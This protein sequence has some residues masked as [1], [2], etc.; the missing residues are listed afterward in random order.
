[1]TEQILKQQMK[2][3]NTAKWDSD[4]SRFRLKK[5]KIGILY[6]LV[7]DW[8]ENHFYWQDQ[9][10]LNQVTMLLTTGLLEEILRELR[11]EL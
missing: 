8:S 6:D 1:M 4:E 11:P 10:E 7:E 9:D 2:L 5:K 3:Y